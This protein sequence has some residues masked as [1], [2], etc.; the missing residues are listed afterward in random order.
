MRLPW[1]LSKVK[2]PPTL[3]ESWVWSLG[4]EDPLEEGRS[5]HSSIL[6]EY[7]ILAEFLENPHGQRRRVGSSAWGHKESHTTERLSISINWHIEVKPKKH[8]L[9][10][11]TVVWNIQPQSWQY[12]KELYQKNPE[13]MVT[14][15]LQNLLWPWGRRKSQLGFPDKES[16]WNAGD[17]GLIPGSGRSPVVREWLP[18]HSSIL[19]CRIP[20]TEKPDG[21]QSMGS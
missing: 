5:T 1:W 18:T 8:C 4:W 16:V 15:A 7:W 2:N 9:L 10:G 11:P 21:L 12:W 19:A 14:L 20:W 6:A 13:R 17:L 3:W